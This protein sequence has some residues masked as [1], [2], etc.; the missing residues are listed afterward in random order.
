[1]PVWL[2]QRR[3]P[4]RNWCRWRHEIQDRPESPIEA[5]D[6]LAAAGHNAMT[7]HEQSLGGAPDEQSDP[8]PFEHSL[9]GIGRV[10]L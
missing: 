5:A 6:L 1:M 4:M 3:W 8:G 7:V 10:L 2:M 9:V